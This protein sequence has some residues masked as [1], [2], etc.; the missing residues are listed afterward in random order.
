MDGLDFQTFGFNKGV[1]S[2]EPQKAAAP[3]R[4]FKIGPTSPPQKNHPYWISPLLRRSRRKWAMSLAPS[5]I[6]Y[7]RCVLG[8]LPPNMI[9]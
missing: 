9:G 5:K 1:D 8:E 3:R 4:Q 2:E 7:L 6:E